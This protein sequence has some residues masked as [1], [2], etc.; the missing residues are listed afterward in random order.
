MKRRFALLAIGV[1]PALAAASESYTIDPYHTIPHFALDYF[2]FGTLTGHFHRTSGRFDVDRAA[3]KASLEFAI[4]AASLTTGD[5]ERGPR[6]RSRD[7]HLRGVDFFNVAE[8][9][10]ITFRSTGA[11]FDGETPAEIDGQL[12][13]LG[14]TKPVRLKVDRW[15]CK[16]HPVYR[17][18]SCGGNASATIRRSEFG[19]KYGLPGVGDEVR[20][21]TFFLGFRN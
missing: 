21:S 9:P 3:R 10:R 16:E 19:M 17:K 20:I 7:E 5:G 2:G 14:V 13:L 11:R 15:V 12:T 1:L 8:F 6:P 4:E 18:Q